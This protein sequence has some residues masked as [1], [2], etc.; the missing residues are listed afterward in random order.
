MAK[1]FIIFYILF[2]DLFHRLT[3]VSNGYYEGL[4]NPITVN[5]KRPIVKTTNTSFKYLFG[6]LSGSV[7]EELRQCILTE[8]L[9]VYKGS[10]SILLGNEI[11]AL[12]DKKGKRIKHKFSL[13][14]GDICGDEKQ[15]LTG[16]FRLTGRKWKTQG[17]YV[18]FTYCLKRARKTREKHILS[19][20]ELKTPAVFL[21]HRVKKDK[22]TG[23]YYYYYYKPVEKITGIF[24][25]P[26][27][28]TLFTV[29]D[30]IKVSY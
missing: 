13:N 21:N 15:R 2:V 9:L 10:I 11:T 17:V 4:E 25:F 26:S 28:D 8:L 14:V 5:V 12:G 16:F 1:I 29:I 3:E 18:R 23:N 20:S 6:M 24:V 27:R 22:T 19:E 30:H 7:N